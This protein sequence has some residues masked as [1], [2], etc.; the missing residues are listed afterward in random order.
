MTSTSKVAGLV[1]LLLAL[2]MPFASFAGPA[3]DDDGDGVFNVLDNC[4]VKPNAGALACDT[5]D[6]G[7]GNACDGD[8]NNDKLV[9]PTDFSAFFLPAFT[10]GVPTAA[11][12]DANCDGIMAPGDFSGGFLPQ[13]GQGAPGVSGLFCA[14]TVPCNL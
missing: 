10:A 14:G 13:F 5:D 12:E 4:R 2:G 3:Q 1:V 7:Y 6:D 11:G 9:T 8:F